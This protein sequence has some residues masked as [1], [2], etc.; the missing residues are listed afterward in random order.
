MECKGDKEN[1]GTECVTLSIN[2]SNYKLEYKR[3][4]KN[5]GR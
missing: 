4:K 2:K 5:S 3:E 1:N